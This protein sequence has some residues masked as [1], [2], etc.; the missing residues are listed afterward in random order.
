MI[1]ACVSRNS[2]TQKYRRMLGKQEG[3]SRKLIKWIDF[4]CSGWVCLFYSFARIV[5]HYRK[6]L[7]DQ[8]RNTKA[9]DTYI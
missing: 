7:D 1:I 3:E 4:T 2:D 5:P 9:E 8:F 6:W